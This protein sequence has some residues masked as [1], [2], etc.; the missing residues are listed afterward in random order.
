MGHSGV[1]SI[2]RRHQGLS[3]LQEQDLVLKNGPFSQQDPG[4]RESTVFVSGNSPPCPCG[5][6]FQKSPVTATFDSLQTARSSLNVDELASAMRD[7]VVGDDHDLSRNTAI[8]LQSRNY[9]PTSS[10]ISYNNF[11][12]PDD[13]SSYPAPQ[14]VRESFSDSPFG[15]AP[16]SKN[17]D[18]P[19]C[20]TPSTQALVYSNIPPMEPH[21]RPSFLYDSAANPRPAPQL[22]H[23][24]QGLINGHPGSSSLATLQ[25]LSGNMSGQDMI[26][27][28]VS[29]GYL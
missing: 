24:S 12:Q 7:M 13:I 6:G 28:Q 29:S 5:P 20:F 11:P 22:Y 17:F 19:A 2:P 25:L 23:S 9:P 26:E 21:R 8:S 4:M 16:Y 3:F 15:Y 1:L 14:H 10:T 27:V 18:P